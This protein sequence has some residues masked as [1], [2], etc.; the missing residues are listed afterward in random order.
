MHEV[1]AIV[2]RHQMR[3]GRA[4]AAVLVGL[5]APALDVALPPLAA[6]RVLGG[7]RM[8]RCA[9]LACT[10]IRLGGAEL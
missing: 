10:L 1:K 6:H 8:A 3:R 7:C 2:F 5:I 9:Q 4:P